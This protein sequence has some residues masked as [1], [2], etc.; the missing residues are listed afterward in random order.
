MEDARHPLGS[1]PLTV[2]V[3]GSDATHCFPVTLTI[4]DEPVS[5]QFWSVLGSSVED[6]AGGSGANAAR[7]IGDKGTW[8]IAGILVLLKHSRIAMDF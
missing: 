4:V 3:D 7:T 6:A 8:R 1:L 5:V 2:S